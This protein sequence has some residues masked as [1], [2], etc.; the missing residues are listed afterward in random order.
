MQKQL[1]SL[2]RKLNKNS[3]ASDLDCVKKAFNFAMKSHEGQMRVSGEPFF[4][5]PIAVANILADMELDSSSVAAALLH[6][7]VEDT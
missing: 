4:T 2:L 7:V 5:H 6:D 3:N 1:D